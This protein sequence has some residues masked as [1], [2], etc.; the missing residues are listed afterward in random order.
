MGIKG[1][2]FK[3]RWLETHFFVHS[4]IGFFENDNND[5]FMCFSFFSLTGYLE[6]R[7]TICDGESGPC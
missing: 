5:G 3:T 2:H 4:L 6:D 1:M 7:E